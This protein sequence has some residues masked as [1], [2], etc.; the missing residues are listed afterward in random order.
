M[1]LFHD[2]I[3]VSHINELVKCND[4][5]FPCNLRALTSNVLKQPQIGRIA[6]IWFVQHWETLPEYPA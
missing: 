6:D 3:A 2:A 4:D 5:F 1:G